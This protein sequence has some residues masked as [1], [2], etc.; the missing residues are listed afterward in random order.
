MKKQLLTILLASASISML[1]MDHRDINEQLA[2]AVL[3]D[4]KQLAQQLIV[5]GADV[6]CINE[7]G[8]S[9]LI[10]ACKEQREAAVKILVELGANLATQD[11]DGRTVFHLG[12]NSKIVFELLTAITPQERKRV[13]AQRATLMTAFASIRYAQPRLP[14]DICK[15]I[16]QRIVKETG[17]INDLVQDHMNQIEQI[18]ALKARR[19]GIR[20]TTLNSAREI[21]MKDQMVEP[22]AEKREVLRSICNLLRLENPENRVRICNQVESNIR[23]ILF[24]PQPEAQP[25]ASKQSANAFEPVKNFDD[26]KELLEAAKA[27]NLRKAEGILAIGTLRAMVGA[28]GVDVEVKDNES[29]LNQ[30]ATPLIW[31]AIKKNLKLCELLIEHNAQV[32]AKDNG[33]WTPLMYAAR[34]GHMNVCK[35]LIASGADINHSTAHSENALNLAARLGHKAVCKLLVDTMLE[36]IK[37]NKAAAIALLGMKKYRTAPCM[38]PIDKHLIGSIAHQLIDPVKTKSLLGLIKSINK[39]EDK[40]ELK[41]ELLTYVHHELNIDQD[42]H[43]K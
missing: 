40:G 21:L 22:D 7:D 31:A 6:N 32:N 16:N 25:I 10:W 29:R 4:N 39:G 19:I 18:L 24:A 15:V 42:N 9:L 35:L 43:S 12:S 17:I 5:Q 23:H 2:Q 37:A 13:E 38:I 41:Q 11:L 34:W 27:G 1:A 3:K 14:R 30:G 20:Y 8:D 36:P 26:G 28:G 33:S